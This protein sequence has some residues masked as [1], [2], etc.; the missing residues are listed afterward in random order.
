[1]RLPEGEQLEIK[2]GD[3]VWIACALLHR[4]NPERTSFSDSEIAN[5]V[6]KESIADSF[7]VGVQWHI[8]LHCVA[9]KPANPSRLRMLY[10]LPDGTKRLF[11]YSDDY[12]FSREDGKITPE[13][14]D[15][16]ESYRY[17]LKWYKD[18][19]NQ[20]TPKQPDKMEQQPSKPIDLPKHD[21]E[22]TTSAL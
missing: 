9:N 19:Y 11:R 10:Q 18:T 6:K 3:E 8:A 20:S 7:R 22:A 16:P 4:E 13:A 5:G 12:H 2:I 17:L 21:I 14:C 15:I 1:L